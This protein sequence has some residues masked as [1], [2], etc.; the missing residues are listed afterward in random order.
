MTEVEEKV[1]WVI[2]RETWLYIDDPSPEIL[3]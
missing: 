2:Q 3:F 1:D